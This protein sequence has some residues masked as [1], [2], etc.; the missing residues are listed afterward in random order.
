MNPTAII[1]LLAAAMTLM[2][3]WQYERASHANDRAKAAESVA[4]ALAEERTR[5]DNA[6][7][8]RDIEISI[9]GKHI[10]DVSERWNKDRQALETCANSVHP[11]LGQWLLNSTDQDRLPPDSKPAAGHQQPAILR[12]DMGG[13]RDPR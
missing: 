7:N 6:L 8:N 3:L 1:G 10:E 13:P 9:L 11:D 4:Q 2:A 12:E 5:L